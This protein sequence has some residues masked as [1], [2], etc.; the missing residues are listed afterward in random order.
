MRGRTIGLAAL[1]AVVAAGVILTPG[2]GASFLTKFKAKK[3]FYTK[4]ESDS[5]YLTQG[6]ADSRYL[7]PSQGDSRYLTPSQ[8]NGNFLP[9]SGAIRINASPMT[10]QK[11]SGAPGIDTLGQ[12]PTSGVTT[13]GGSSGALNDVPVAIEPTLPTV[14]VGKPLTFVG[15][16]ACYGTDNTTL[17]TVRINLTANSTGL[18]NGSELLLD[19][20]DRTDDACRDYTLSTPH[21]MAPTEDINLE[22]DVDYSSNAQFFHAE[23]ATFIFQL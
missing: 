3:L 20:T 18:G 17:D 8:A 7:T 21:V 6:Q 23:R 19:T 13:F 12:H 9:A 14:L 11:I 1:C 15:V 10:W 4:S 5:R 2:F 22:F 16:N